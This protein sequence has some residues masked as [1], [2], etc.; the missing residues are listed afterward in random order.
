MLS[1]Q[2]KILVKF[3]ERISPS[4]L[5]KLRILM[6]TGYEP[7]LELIPYLCEKDK[8][9]IDVGAAWGKY[10]FYMKKFS[11]KCWAFEPIPRNVNLLNRIFRK[12][13]II[14]PVAL[15]D[16]D[17][18]AKIRIPINS[19]GAASIEEE[20][21]LE[22]LNKINIVNVSKKRLD[23]YEI[24]TIGLMKIDV[25]GHEEAV[26]RGSRR[27][28]IRDKPA[29]IIESEERHKSNTIENTY[30][31]LHELGYEGFFFFNKNLRKIE[32]FDKKHHQNVQNLKDGNKTG[33][34]VNNFIF[35]T[36]ESIPKISKFLK[37]L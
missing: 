26:L 13:V 5:L 31:F 10:T 23:D 20:N 17:G 14:Q 1:K 29:L 30:N 24:D 21:P 16:N 22:G 9:S 35:L 36:T 11:K 2:K 8:I 25:E 6:K 18:T 15:S 19:L 28:L 32:E 27:L 7:E 12:N 4:L 3:L 34:Y 37:S 33:L